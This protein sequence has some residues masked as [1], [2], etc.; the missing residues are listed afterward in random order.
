MSIAAMFTTNETINID[1]GYGEINGSALSSDALGESENLGYISNYSTVAD[2]LASKGEKLDASNEPTNGQ[3]Y[4]A[5]AEAKALG[6][7]S[8][9]SGVD[10]YV[11]FSSTLPFSYSRPATSAPAL[12]ISSAPPNTRSPR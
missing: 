1:V 9:S 3:F 4:V 8:N 12:M 6:L 11:G 5:S 7:V 10:G 2:A